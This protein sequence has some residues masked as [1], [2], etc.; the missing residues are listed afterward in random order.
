MSGLK[1]SGVLAVVT[2]ENCRMPIPAAAGGVEVRAD[3]FDSREES[4]ELIAS[5]SKTRPVLVTPRHTSQGGSWRGT[6]LERAA[7]CLEA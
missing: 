2:P 5:I 7:Y 3:L 6:E 1:L 4:L